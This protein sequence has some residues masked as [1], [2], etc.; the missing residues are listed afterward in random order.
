MRGAR[1][2]CPHGA[3]PAR[4]S[5]IAPGQPLGAHFVVT[6]SAADRRGAAS[7]RSPTLHR[8]D[9]ARRRPLARLVLL[10]SLP[11]ELRH[12]ARR[13]P[14]L[15]LR[16]DPGLARFAVAV[17]RGQERCL[18]VRELALRSRERFFERGDLA[19]GV[20]RVGSPAL[21]LGAGLE[22]EPPAR[23]EAAVALFP[24]VRQRPVGRSRP[25]TA[26]T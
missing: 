25:S 14:L 13:L 7:A 12:P 5:S 1:A 19:Y 6:W 20:G 8:V 10:G 16:D 3:W 22:Q 15:L 17:L 24:A 4:L 11:F 18:C 2:R 9:L 23:D 21:E 26:I